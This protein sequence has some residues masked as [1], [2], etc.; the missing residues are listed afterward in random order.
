MSYEESLKSISL[1]ADASIGIY[2]GVPGTPGSP[3]PHGGKQ[4]YF[5]KV[6]G[7]GQCGLATGTGDAIG[8]LQNKPQGVGHAATVGFSGVSN[9]VAGGAITAGNSIKADAN[10]KAVAAT[11]PADAAVV[12]AV[13][14]GTATAADQLIPALL[15]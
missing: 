12:L 1:V 8:V 6:T 7:V 9:V 4:Y 2:T 14:I 5:V 13:A 15:V 3:Q 11:L 10:G